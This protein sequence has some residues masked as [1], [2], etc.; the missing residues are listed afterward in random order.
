[1]TEI[2]FA[3][4]I[5]AT[6]RRPLLRVGLVLCALLA[7]PMLAN[8][9][10]LLS[11][12]LSS[13]NATV[14][15]SLTATVHIDQVADLYAYQFDLVF[16]PGLL[17]GGAMTERTFLSFA[18]GTTFLAGTVDNM[19]GTV[20]NVANTLSGAIAGADGSGDWVEFSFDAV[21]AGLASLS[22]ANVFALDS[23][24]GNI[25]VGLQGA[26]VQI[27]AAGPTPTP[28]PGTLLLVLPLAAV[29]VARGNRCRA[30]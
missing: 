23:T 27:S 11:I 30:V 14:G 21:G 22:L 5:G 7:T 19:L 15:D 4:R 12:V 25:T 13:A 10:P 17:A 24:F 26:S 16:S 9:T 29:L 18:G 6:L 20:V 2:H 8:S 1:M 3:A 28:E